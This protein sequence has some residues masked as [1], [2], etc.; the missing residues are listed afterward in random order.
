MIELVIISIL[1]VGFVVTCLS[2]WFY[3]KAYK[4]WE[5]NYVFLLEMYEEAI[6]EFE[7]DGL[8]ND[9]LFLELKQVALGLQEGLEKMKEE[10]VQTQGQEQ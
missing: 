7:K 9:K 3:R 8:S 2:C 4:E 5:S 6:Q 10:L 1:W